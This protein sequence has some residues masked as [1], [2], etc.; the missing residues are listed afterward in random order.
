MT[1]HP[2]GSGRV[3]ASGAGAKAA[4]LDRAAA[5]G[6]DVPNGFVV[7]DGV[8]LDDTS[9]SWS[10]AAAS[11]SLGPTVA[12][13]SAFSAE[14]GE[15]TAMAGR[16]ETEL[17]VENVESA[18]I[19]AVER[20]RA[21]GEVVPSARRD[22]LVMQMVK[23]QRAGV[24]F[25][26]QQFED[27]LVNV[28]SGL[29]DSLVS[30]AEAGEE[31]RLAKVRWLERPDKSLPPWQ[32]RLALL[33][34]EVR[35]EF[36]EREWDI[37]WADD[38]ETCWLVQLRPITAAPRRNETFTIANHKEILPEL[39]SV[40][41]ASLVE[42][43]SHDLMSFYRD[44][45]PD[46]PV[47]RPFIESFAGRPYIN[48]SQLTDLLR[49]L[50]LPTALLADSLGGEPELLVGP[51]PR[52]LLR[53]LPTLI[54][55]GFAQLTSAGRAADAEKAI[56]EFAAA[57][58]A[59]F[60]ATLGA[61]RSC[62]VEL[63]TQMSSLAT[64]MTGPVAILRLTGSLENH[65][66]SQ[67]TPGTRMLDDLA[68]MAA[69]ARSDDAVKAELV[70]G[71]LP[72][73]PAFARLWDAW[74]A[75]HGHRGVFESDVARPRFAEAPAPILASILSHKDNSHSSSAGLKDRLTW[76]IWFFARRPM[77]AREQIRWSAMR[78]FGI[79]RARLLALA[80]EA[81]ADGRLPEVEAVWDLAIDELIGL[82]C[83]VAFSAE[84]LAERRA[85]V[86]ERAEHRL[87]DLVR[88]FDD[89]AELSGT[90]SGDGS[91]V[92]SGV[93]LTTG[94]VRGVALRCAEPPAGLPDGFDAETTVL[95]ARS[96][97]AGWV[98]SFGQVAGV[99]VE[100]GGDL[101]H[102][103]IILRELG[104]PAVTNLGEIGDEIL[105]GDQVVLDAGA[106]R[107]VRIDPDGEAEPGDVDA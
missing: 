8:A 55:L 97:D 50:G 46:L 62:Y 6:I 52:R 83:G 4:N 85:L 16:F 60:D 23:A 32:Q 98:P 19:A 102:G 35:A 76:P 73:D 11:I 15:A 30:G 105:T 89:L 87:P 12:V 70:A 29:A 59:D 25:T 107:L 66:R 104:L 39:P 31:L 27:D 58:L 41:M 82:D 78:S 1:A 17:G 43:S 21:S 69:L 53:S 99:A 61:L 54:K 5:A 47:D 95:V 9:M 65:L 51:N 94:E 14:D 81:V 80:A 64:A 48:L 26:E 28:V 74:V 101:S 100:I 72:T 49:R 24:L 63:V 42:S 7:P 75:Q 34:R 67:R 71:R 91:G 10:I 37:E 2:L 79:I 36:G 38:G 40:L 93:S 103:S 45:D 77:A 68:P 18:V 33:M 3:V 88:R 57:D 90:S 84:Q 44:I 106:G 22:V 92:F 96:V 86:A 13:R 20:V 56:A